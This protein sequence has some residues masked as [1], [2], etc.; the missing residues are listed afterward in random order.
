MDR[1]NFIA[2][3]VAGSSILLLYSHLLSSCGS[4][5]NEVLNIPDDTPYNMGYIS[6][7]VGFFTERGG[8][9]V[10]MKSKK[11]LVIVDT[12]FPDQSN[13]LI[14]QLIANSKRKV[15]AVINTH[16]HGDHTSGNIV[17]KNLTDKIIAHSNSKKNQENKAIQSQNLD[18]TLLPNLTFE[19]DYQIQVDEEHI[20]MDYLGPA[21]T[22]GDIAVHFENANVVHLGDLIFNRRFPYIDMAAGADIENWIIVLDKI[23][24]KYSKNTTY[25]FGHSDNGYDIKGDNNDIIAFRNYLE[26]LM[27]FGEDCKKSGKSLEEALL[28]KTIPGAEEWSGKG[29]ERSIKAVYEQLSI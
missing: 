6:N 13:H 11:G 18:N 4:K 17:F 10:W 25:V 26:R 14:T 28:I 3:T 19:N 12:Q 16:H 1:R 23:L 24:K 15:D 21:H 7:S 20:K 27:L 22:N 29:I 2:N 8:T 5:A 9:I